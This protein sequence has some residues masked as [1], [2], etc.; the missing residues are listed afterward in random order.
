MK[1]NQLGFAAATHA[2][3]SSTKS[4]NVREDAVDDPHPR[5]R[6]DWWF[7]IASLFF[8]IVSVVLSSVAIW[9]IEHVHTHVAEVIARVYE[10]DGRPLNA[11]VC[12]VVAHL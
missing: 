11:S 3:A 8:G 1:A 9:R 4:V 7:A 2:V 6:V 12:G 5:S 10:C